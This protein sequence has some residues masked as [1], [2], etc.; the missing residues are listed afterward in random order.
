MFWDKVTRAQG[1]WWE[2]VAKEAK[3]EAARNEN[4]AFANVSDASDV[5]DDDGGGGGYRSSTTGG[6]RG[7]ARA[8]PPPFAPPRLSPA[9]ATALKLAFAATPKNAAKRAPSGG[10]AASETTSDASGKKVG[11]RKKPPGAPTLVSTQRANNVAIVLQRLPGTP[12]ELVG[13]VASGNASGALDRDALEALAS[14]APTSEEVDAFSRMRASGTFPLDESAL[15]P[16]ERFL[17]KMAQARRVREKMDCIAFALEFE[18]AVEAM[19]DALG[20]VKRACTEVRRSRSLRRVLAAALAAG[21][22]LNEG[23]PR[24]GALGFTID[25]LHK[26]ADVKSTF[27]SSGDD[28]DD[29]GA[30]RDGEGARAA[31]ARVATLLDFVVAVADDDDENADLYSENSENSGDLPPGTTTLG[32][33]EP[34]SLAAEL[35]SCAAAARRSRGEL[36]NELARLETGAERVRKEAEASARAAAA[37]AEKESEPRDDSER[38]AAEA[39]AKFADQS[40]ARRRTLR[41][42]AAYVDEKYRQ[43]CAWMGESAAGPGGAAAD[44]SPG[45]GGVVRDLDETFGGLHAFAEAVDAARARRSDARA[46]QRER[47]KRAEEEREREKR[48]RAAKYFDAMD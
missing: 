26:L 15:T 5:S 21:N 4:G 18:D 1:T 3:E 35:A 32:T 7:R 31:P 2:D 10:G 14:C 17:A 33:R 16:P 8:P 11:G 28:P 12:A 40:E 48:R 37:D 19:F 46:K 43:L 38:R 42:E 22:A 24:G 41:A 27:R 13:H 23:T 34:R 30:S 20:A 45:D 6:A 9:H 47:R 39:F 44:G 29:E 36:A 25:S